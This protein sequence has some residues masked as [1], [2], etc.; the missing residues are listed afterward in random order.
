MLSIIVLAGGK[1]E[2]FQRKME[3]WVDKL[4]YRV[5]GE[6]IIRRV[7]KAAL[8]VSDDVIISTDSEQRGVTYA[9]EVRDIGEVKIS[10]DITELGC[11]GPLLGITSSIN[12][13]K[14]DYIC[15]IAG[16]LPFIT[17]HV[18]ENLMNY[19]DRAD[20]VTPYWGDGSVESLIFI[21]NK[22]KL[23]LYSKFL[24]IHGF[25]RSSGIQRISLKTLYVP[26]NRLTDD[27]R[28]FLDVNYRDDL[29]RE[30]IVPKIAEKEL[31]ITFNSDLDMGYDEAFSIGHF[32][33]AAI[34]LF[35]E[36]SLDLKLRSIKA[37]E[38]EARFYMKH[39]L[40]VFASQALFD[41]SKV[42]NMLGFSS[43]ARSYYRKAFEISKT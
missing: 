27:V 15:V 14:G 3:P 16:D 40:K 1:A 7:L 13:V 35:R 31:L 43:L 20:V 26:A 6:S 33:L 34:K 24:C 10:V 12:H 37:F 25:W 19:A 17:S 42:L 36:R 32:F 30:T 4:L 41:A 2:R 28:V 39:G 22:S 11:D 5:E 21:A 18:I 23:E 9:N 8:A 29:N 38:Q